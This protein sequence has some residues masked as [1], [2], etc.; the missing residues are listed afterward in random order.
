MC[1]D[2]AFCLVARHPVFLFGRQGRG[3]GHDMISF[4]LCS[5]RSSYVLCIISCRDVIE[6]EQEG[7]EDYVE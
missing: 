6:R 2:I 1:T 4:K 5:L 3:H 7:I